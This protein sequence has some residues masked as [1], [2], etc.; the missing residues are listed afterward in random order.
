[1]KIL[2]SQVKPW[3]DSELLEEV[4]SPS[5]LILYNDDYNTF[6]HVIECL[7][8]YCEHDVMQAEQCAL[9]VHHTGKC[10]VKEGTTEELIPI[11]EALLNQ[12][13]SVLLT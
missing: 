13:L 11:C 5:Q 9:I 6:D 10:S 3:E 12:G 7:I 2:N 4:E 8:A 1:M